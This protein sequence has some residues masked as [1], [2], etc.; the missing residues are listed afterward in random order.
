VEASV[1]FNDQETDGT[2]VVVARASSP[3]EAFV[4]ITSESGDP[5]VQ[6][7]E[8]RINLSP[9]KIV[10]NVTVTLESALS[11]S[12]QLTARLQESNGGTLDTDSAHVTL[13]GEPPERVDGFDP[14]FVEA[15]PDAG[16]Q[17]PYY[18]YAADSFVGAEPSPML[19]ETNNTG[20][21]TDD[22]SVHRRAAEELISGGF[23]RRLADELRVP[24]LVPVFPRPET[25]PVDW[26]HYT[27]QLD[28][29][30]LQVSDGPLERIDLQ[31]L[32]M[33]DDAQQRLESEL[34]PAADDIMLNGFSASGNFVDRFTVLHPDRVRSVTA[35][36]LNGMTVL[37][38]SEMNGRTLNYHVGIADVEELTGEAVEVDALDDVNQFPYMGG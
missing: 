14:R 4:V 5:L 27:H 25:E 2:T 36:G 22:F 9:G 8:N 19:V 33:V 38:L 17:Y 32:R 10:E 29:Q 37:P 35:G 16:F 1:T 12:Q 7:P 13:V 21:A 3:V 31:L 6:G 26:R 24:L 34:Y 30:T 15:N 18:L 11:K 28:R 23:P 20:T